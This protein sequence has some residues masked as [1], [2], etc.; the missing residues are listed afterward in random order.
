MLSDTDWPLAE[1]A[2]PF[3][4]GCVS[5][6]SM[7]WK[8]ALPVSTVVAERLAANEGAFLQLRWLLDGFSLSDPRVARRLF[9]LSQHGGLSFVD[10]H[11]VAV[12]PAT[13][14]DWEKATASVLAQIGSEPTAY[15]A[16]GSGAKLSETSVKCVL[17][18]LVD[19][20]VVEAF[21]PAGFADWST[22][23]FARIAPPAT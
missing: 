4:A 14:G 16:I 17:Q 1:Y 5:L 11:V 21:T 2:S 20:R 18:V 10:D 15:A 3:A 19:D 23:S 7:G 6:P 13:A 9:Q 8:V 12:P 22:M